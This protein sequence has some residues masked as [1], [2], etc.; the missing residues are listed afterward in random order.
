MQRSSADT[1]D[2]PLAFVMLAYPWGERGELAGFSGPDCWH[3][4]F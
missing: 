2:D 3:A 4:S 1:Y